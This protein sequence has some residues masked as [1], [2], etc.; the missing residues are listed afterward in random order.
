MN[1]FNSSISYRLMTTDDVERVPLLHQGTPEE[2]LDR[3]AACG[4]S[5]MLAFEGTTHVGQLQFRLYLP[6]ILSLHGLHDPLY[7]MDFG[8]HAPPMPDRTLA[9]FCYHVGQ[10]DNTDRRDP[11]YVGRG[12]GTRLLDE[13]LSW[14][15]QVGF[16]AIVAKGLTSIWPIPQFMGGMPTEI[17]LS[18]KF[19]IVKSYQDPYL[20]SWINETLSSP[21][22]G[23]LQKSLRSITEKGANPE[24]IAKI[25]ICVR[26]LP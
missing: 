19:T 10:L 5:A 15:T 13:T 20:L 2:V 16:S 23:D 24:D 17:Y 25:S 1:S 11:R 6:G 7:W 12:I 8:D 18:R 26:M 21:H 14:A 22:G 4:S 9:L 3:I